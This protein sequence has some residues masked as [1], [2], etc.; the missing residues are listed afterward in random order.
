[1]QWALTRRYWIA[2]TTVAQMVKNMPAM[3]ESWIQSLG[4]EDPL[5]KAM[6]THSS[7]L[8]WEILWT[9]EPGRLQSM[10]SQRVR[11]NWATNTHI[12]THK[13]G[14]FRGFSKHAAAAS[15]LVAMW[16]PLGVSCTSSAGSTNTKNKQLKNPWSRDF[17]KTFHFW[18]V[19]TYIQRT[20]LTAFV[21]VFHSAFGCDHLMKA[22]LPLFLKTGV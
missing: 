3:Q 14:W 21:T 2:S 22:C 13:R 19:L 7:N 12:R 20:S 4:W 10:G 18:P 6:A 16:M 15:A 8:A 17:W 1:M 5:E 11:H 9:E